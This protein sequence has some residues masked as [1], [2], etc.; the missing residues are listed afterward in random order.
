MKNEIPGRLDDNQNKNGMALF[1]T[2]VSY[3]KMAS[4]ILN[5]Q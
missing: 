5:I 2:N 4:M 1:D 3:K